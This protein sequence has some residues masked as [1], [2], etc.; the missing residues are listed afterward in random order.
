VAVAVGA[1]LSIAEL[2]SELECHLE[3]VN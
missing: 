3:V 2:E 1:E